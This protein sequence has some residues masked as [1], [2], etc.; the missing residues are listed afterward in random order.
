MNSRTSSTSQR[1]HHAAAML[2]CAAAVAFGGPAR[3]GEPWKFRH[4]FADR[5]LPGSSWG[6]TAAADLDRDGR[7]DLITGRSRGEIL[8]YRL[9]TSGPTRW[10]PTAPCWTWTATA[11]T[12]W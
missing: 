5:D 7:P 3:A 8:W 2:A 6:Q 1:G 4:H 10:P 11:T 12:T 9:E